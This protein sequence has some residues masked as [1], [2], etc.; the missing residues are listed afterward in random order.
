[1]KSVRL[2][3]YKSSRNKNWTIV[4]CVPR[5][6]LV[7]FRHTQSKNPINPIIYNGGVGHDSRTPFDFTGNLIKSK[8]ICS[9]ALTSLFWYL[10]SMIAS[11]MHR[12]CV[13]LYKNNFFFIYFR[14][15]N[16]MNLNCKS[17]IRS[18]CYLSHKWYFRSWWNK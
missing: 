5:A 4:I 12:F 3:K 16:K 8:L 7:M 18:E 6:V 11:N 15:P 14:V 10:N 2:C 13:R 1:M 17:C 9:F